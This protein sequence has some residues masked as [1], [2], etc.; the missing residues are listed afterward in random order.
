M[1][2]RAQMEKRTAKDVL[3][4]IDAWEDDNAIDA[5]MERVLAMTPEEREAELR[6]AGYDVEAEKAKAR[7]WHETAKRGDVTDLGRLAIARRRERTEEGTA[8][9]ALAGLVA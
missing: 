7:A 4:T 9:K 6:A 2:R 3:D 8:P 1:V 5:E